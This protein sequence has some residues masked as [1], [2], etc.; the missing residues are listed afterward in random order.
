MPLIC[1]YLSLIRRWYISWAYF[2]TENISFYWGIKKNIQAIAHARVPVVKLVFECGL[3]CDICVNNTLA[4]F[5]SHMLRAYALLDYNYNYQDIKRVPIISCTA[6]CVLNTSKII[7][8]KK[9]FYNTS[10]I[11]II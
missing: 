2:C 9:V 8:N 11:I 1:W 4:I 7:K 6:C 10:I 3:E 5:N